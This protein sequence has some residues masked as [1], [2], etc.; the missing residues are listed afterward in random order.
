MSFTGTLRPYQVE[1]VER[2]KEQ[3]RILLAAEQGTGKTTMTIAAIEDLFDADCI[4]QP[5]LVI[6]LSTLKYQWADKIQE[7]TDGTSQALVVD[8]TPKQ[9]EKQ[10]AEAMNWWH[11]GVDYV[12]VN[13][14]Q[15]LNEWG[16]IE[17]LPRGFIVV[18]EA[19]FIRGFKAQRSRA[20][21]ELARRVP[22]RYA[23]TGTPIENGKPEEM[24]SIMEYVDKDV[25]GPFHIFDRAFMVRNDKGWV[26]RYRN[27][28]T[29]Q[30]TLAKSMIRLRASDPEVA[31]YM[32][33]VDDK[34][35]MLVPLDKAGRVLYDHIAKGLLADLDEAAKWGRDFDINVH[36]GQASKS[37]WDPAD[38]VKGRIG[39]KLMALQ[40]L[41]DHPELLQLSAARYAEQLAGNGNSGSAYIYGLQQEGRL[42]DLKRAPKFDFTLKWVKQTLEVDERNKIVIFTRFVNMAHLVKNGIGNVATAYTGELTAKQKDASLKKFQNTKDCRVL[43]AT[44]AGGF[45]LDIPQA[46]TLLNYDLPDGAG[47]AD[48]RDTRI[49]RTS[50]TFPTVYRNW[51]FIKGSIEERKNAV[52]RQ[53]RAVAGAFVDAKGLNYKGGV[54]L[55][56]K[57]L[58]AYLRESS[59]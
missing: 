19:S 45:G 28:P 13:Y 56:A 2:M 51:V 1:P 40:M 30:Q 9:R 7:F 31:P 12:I 42:A 17:E 46:N 43:V 41:C 39:Q 8:G 59:P 23:L 44:D 37:G 4:R 11:S 18:D 22:Y 54:D 36:Y 32:P 29:F 10:Y 24:F 25:F 34:T 57:T 14:E 27:I 6:C 21:K 50:S 55:T 33:Q 52:L 5:G 48:Q 15:V 16:Y 49:V 38:Q 58:T 47:L 20:V 3:G 53:K 26:T 35:P